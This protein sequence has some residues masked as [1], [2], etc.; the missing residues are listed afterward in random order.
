MSEGMKGGRGGLRTLPPHPA[1]IVQAKTLPPHPAKIAQ[2]KALP[3]HPATIVQAKVPFPHPAPLVDGARPKKAPPLIAPNRAPLIQRA[4]NPQA[5][6]S[7]EDQ[8]R[9]YLGK[10]DALL[11]WAGRYKQP[12]I[13]DYEGYGDWP[14]Q[15]TTLRTTI[16]DAQSATNVKAAWN[17][18]K[19]SNDWNTLLALEEARK[20]W[21]KKEQENRE[22]E[23]AKLE[24]R[25]RT[26]E[27]NRRKQLKVR[28]EEERLARAQKER[29]QKRKAIHKVHCKHFS[30]VDTTNY[31]ITDTTTLCT[32]FLEGSDDLLYY[33]ISGVNNH[34]PFQAFYRDSEGEIQFTNTAIDYAELLAPLLGKLRGI[35]QAEEWDVYVCAEVD[36]VVKLL[37]ETQ[38]SLFGLKTYAT[39]NELNYKPPCNNCSQWVTEV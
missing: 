2:A 29:D 7:L 15:F 3:P 8:V 21:K 28:E 33:G 12:E 18:L 35:R 1:K 6:P 39:T 19:K 31:F 10:I 13:V 5:K 32:A 20:A 26:E 14:S 11:E 27:G 23:E 37:L 16:W 24:Q 36:A 22:A 4:E 9:E 34:S 25:R 30:Q 17:T 38:G